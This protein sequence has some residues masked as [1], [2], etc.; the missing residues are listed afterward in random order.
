MHAQA[1]VVAHQLTIVGHVGPFQLF[2]VDAT[3]DEIA[4]FLET[5]DV[6]LGQRLELVGA[7]HAVLVGVETLGRHRRI[8]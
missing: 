3:I 7:Q 6:F 2:A 4:P 1:P 5:I 8:I